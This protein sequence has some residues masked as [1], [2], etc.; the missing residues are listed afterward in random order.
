[1]EALQELNLSHKVCNVPQD[2]RFCICSSDHNIHLTG[3]GRH[4]DHQF[5]C[6]SSRCKHFGASCQHLSVLLCQQLTDLETMLAV[7]QLGVT[8]WHS[9]RKRAAPGCIIADLRHIMFATSLHSTV[10]LSS[11]RSLDVSKNQVTSLKALS[12]LPGM[13]LLGLQLHYISTLL[14]QNPQGCRC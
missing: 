5:C 8:H 6:K 1:M 12:S 3:L 11:L 9:A 7:Q 4:Q 10:Q 2:F 13:H 14:N